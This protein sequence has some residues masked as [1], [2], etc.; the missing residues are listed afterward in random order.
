MA[1]TDEQPGQAPPAMKRLEMYLADLIEVYLILWQIVAQG[2]AARMYDKGK[3][4]YPATWHGT[5]HKLNIAI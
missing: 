4:E 3:A 2:R 1:P 5:V